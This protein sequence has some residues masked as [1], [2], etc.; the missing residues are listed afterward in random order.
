MIG[1]KRLNHYLTQA[2]PNMKLKKELCLDPA[3][4]YISGRWQGR[5]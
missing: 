2:L 4:G 1:L 3:Q 5:N